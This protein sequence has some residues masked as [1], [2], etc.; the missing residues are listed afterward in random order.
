[1]RQTDRLLYINFHLTLLK[2]DRQRSL[3]KQNILAKPTSSHQTGEKGLP[4]LFITAIIVVHRAYDGK[5][6]WFHLLHITARQD[7][8]FMLYLATALLDMLGT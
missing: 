2:G 1:M 3:S 4:G 8:K 7:T 6:E 5:S